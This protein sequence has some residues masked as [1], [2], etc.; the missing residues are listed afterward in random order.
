MNHFMIHRVALR[1]DKSEAFIFPC[2]R[3]HTV[4]WKGMM[5]RLFL[6]KSSD[7]RVPYEWAEDMNKA[8]IKFGLHVGGKGKANDYVIRRLARQAM[9]RDF[10]YVSLGG[11]ES[12]DESV[13]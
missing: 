9:K 12:C 7:Y 4:I 6:V 8:K 1:H 13:V 2:T 11:R 3:A 10:F 5:I